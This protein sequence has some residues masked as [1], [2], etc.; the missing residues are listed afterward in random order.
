MNTALLIGTEHSIQRGERC[1]D[2]FESTLREICRGNRVAAIAEEINESAQ[3]VASTLA[4]E[5]KISHLF[6]DP[7]NTERIE[8]GIEMDIALN[9][10]NEFKSKYPM[11]CLWP[12]EPSSENLPQEVWNEHVRRTEES[13]RMR[14]SVWLEKIVRLDKWPL[15]FICG[16]DHFGSFGELLRSHR[17]DVVPIMFDVALSRNC[18]EAAQK[19]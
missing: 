3:T 14:E 19:Q 9:L 12:R 17:I 11:L 5:L 16:N 18:Q 6:A 7:G 8:R 13:Y 2:L 1:R 4:Q 15:L 10:I